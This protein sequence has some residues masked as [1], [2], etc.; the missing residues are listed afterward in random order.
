MYL[1]S[2]PETTIIFFFA[3]FI[4]HLKWNVILFFAYCCKYLAFYYWYLFI[5]GESTCKTVFC[6][7]VAFLKQ[8]C[9]CTAYW[10]LKSVQTPNK[11]PVL[12][13]ECVYGC[14]GLNFI[15]V[16][17]MCLTSS[18]CANEKVNHPLIIWDCRCK[19]VCVIIW[20]STLNSDI[21]VCAVHFFFLLLFYE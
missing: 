3:L 6:L 4:F 16:P 14:K 8:E 19:L 12:V 13:F 10:K 11:F 7:S 17:D 9:S 2:R 15:S 21:Y 1:F 20:Y 18:C 5:C